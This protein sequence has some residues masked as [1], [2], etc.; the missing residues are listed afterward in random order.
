VK[1]LIDPRSQKVIRKFCSKIGCKYEDAMKYYTLRSK[2]IF[3]INH[4]SL[5]LV[6]SN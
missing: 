4:L 1:E 6:P 2:E 5:M 3:G